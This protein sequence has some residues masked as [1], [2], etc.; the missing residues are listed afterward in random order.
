VKRRRRHDPDI[1]ALDPRELGARAVVLSPHLD[2]A[3]FSVGATIARASRGG[4][5]VSVLTI[6]A[7]DP[8]SSAPAGEWDRLAGFVTAGQAATARRCED[9]KACSLLS[10]TPVWQPFFD[11]QYAD[12]PDDGAL[13]Y[14]LEEALRAA[15]TLLLPGFPLTHP[16]HLRLVR[17]VL[18][19]GLFRGRIGLYAEQPYML[20]EGRAGALESLRDLVPETIRWRG[21][22]I[23]YRDLALK[24]IAC[25]AY[26]SQL[27]CIPHR[28]VWPMSRYEMFS[29]D[30][31]AFVDSA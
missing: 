12:D 31:V 22:R 21:T 11:E 16:D 6:F 14:V 5:R 18:A 25:R 19:A 29:G 17:L 20:W 24:V 10:A 27:A 8:Q 30:V 4:A 3:V 9:W 28:I 13:A 1:P 23:G 7:G 26:S 2:D 15:D